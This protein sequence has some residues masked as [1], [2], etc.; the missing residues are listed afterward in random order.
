MDNEIQITKIVDEN[1]ILLFN[2][3]KGKRKNVNGIVNIPIK[4]KL[5][6]QDLQILNLL[7]EY[8]NLSISVCDCE[9]TYVL[10]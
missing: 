5:K 10:I 8:E 2:T 9:K 6:N 4:R 7:L 3:S 1:N